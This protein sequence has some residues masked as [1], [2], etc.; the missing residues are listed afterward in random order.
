[1]AL[2]NSITGGGN[3]FKLAPDLTFPGDIAGSGSFKR[4]V[5]DPSGALTTAL[6]LTGKFVID[7]LYFSGL[8]AETIT[9]KLTVDGV[10]I[11]N[12]TFT[13]T[14]TLALLSNISTVS[15]SSISITCG[16]SFLL[17]LQTATDTSV[18]LDYLARP[19]L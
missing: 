1:M 6:S 12:D 13:T 18:T 16:S 2:L 10:V 8:T 3:G 19:I 11:W 7:T 15:G 5:F 17:E 14:T 4:L 9:V